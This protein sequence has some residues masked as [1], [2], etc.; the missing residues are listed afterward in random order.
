MNS[1]ALIRVHPRLLFFLLA[2]TVATA[3]TKPLPNQ[4]GN[5]DLD[6]AGTVLLERA[7]VQDVA[8]ADLGTGYVVVRI[9]ATPKAG[10]PLRIGPD[11]FVLLN[12]KNGDRSPAL[13]PAQFGSSGGLVVKKADKQPGGDGTTTNGPLWSGVQS[14]IGGDKGGAPALPL[15]KL[16]EKEL[17]DKEN[18][19]PV[20]GLLYF[21]LDGKL[22]PKDVSLIYDGLAGKLIMDFK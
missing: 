13:D 12:R 19:T 3:E 22:K 10:K 18:K 16:K 1:S 17:P 4:A 15:Q 2:A 20:E 21:A 7:A 11:D 9:S 8:G 14:R 6:I 5:D